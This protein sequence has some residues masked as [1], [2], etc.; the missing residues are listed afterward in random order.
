MTAKHSWAAVILLGAA[1]SSVRPGTGASP[2]YEAERAAMVEHLRSQ[3]IRSERVL[4]AMGSVPRHRFVSEEH[5]DRAYDDVPLLAAGGGPACCR[6]YV[7][8]LAAQVLDIEPDES[9][10]QVGAESGYCIAILSHLTS[11]LHVMDARPKVAAAA[12][13]RLEA[14]GSSSPTWE[15]GQ[16]CKV[17]CAGHA[18][19]DAILMTCATK[20][21]PDEL[22][23]EL[24][25][26]GRMVVPLDQGPEQ[27]LTCVRKTAPVT[28]T[29]KMLQ[30]RANIAECKRGP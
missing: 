19:Y 22:F 8:A 9:V 29:D 24:A 26:N 16:A 7:V 14:A 10:L 25:D 28:R 2:R 13:K 20:L 6:P 30:L 5:Q 15:N 4:A 11:K 12:R 17:G 21:V 23:K 3:G 27:T 18:P 1:L